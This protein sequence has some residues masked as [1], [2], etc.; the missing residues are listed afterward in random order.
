M[1]IF[2]FLIQVVFQLNHI[3]RTP[4]D[5]ARNLWLKSLGFATTYSSS[6]QFTVHGSRILNH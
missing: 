4:V 3:L 5:M 2:I 6:L 1:K